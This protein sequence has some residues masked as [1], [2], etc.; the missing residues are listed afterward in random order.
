MSQYFF[1]LKENN[2]WQPAVQKIGAW[3]DNEVNEL[4]FQVPNELG[5]LDVHDAAI[6]L[7]AIR[8]D[9]MRLQYIID[10]FTHRVTRDMSLMGN[11][12]CSIKFM[13]G[14]GE[15]YATENFRLIVSPRVDT[16]E[17][18]NTDP[19]FFEEMWRKIQAIVEAGVPGPEGP[20]G[21]RGPRGRR[22]R[23]GTTGKAI[24]ILGDL[25]DESELPLEGTSGDAYL[26]NGYLWVWSTSQNKFVDMGN[27]QGPKGDTGETGLQGPRGYQGDKGNTGLQGN[28]GETGAVGPQGEQ[29]IEGPQGEQGVQGEAG[30][31]GPIGLQGEIGPVGPQGDQGIQ[32]ERGE[33]GVIGNT[34]PKGDTGSIGPQGEQGAG[35]NILG[36]FNTE[37]ELRDAHPTGSP[38]DAYMV[39]PEMWVWSVDDWINV[40][41][42]Q[43]PQ[44]DIGPQG[45]IGP[46]GDQG[47][48]G[49]KG[50]QGIQGEIGPTGEQGPIGNTGATGNTGPK[51]DQGVPG[52]QGPIGNTGST[53][54]TGAQG[55]QGIPGPQGDIGPEGPQGNIGPKGDTGNTGPTGNTG[56]TG[57]A[58]TSVT[59]IEAANDTQAQILS[60]ANPNNVYFVAVG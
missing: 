15:V 40:G 11:Y 20:P 49:E 46:K 21:E 55:E 10:D 25:N 23:Q 59:V 13:W 53:G 19:T 34:G 12:A 56:A 32:G 17:V 47:I 50:D 8:P 41:N 33:Q 60:Q 18:Y 26:I 2:T 1:T 45:N 31:T 35:V 14:N 6:T 54:A 7:H 51:G 42:I 39:G 4:I 37:Q 48:Q 38:G 28:T 16:D 22:G 5:G 52:E 9:G 27:I 29:G 44:G 30:P 57:P 3:R 58:G 36:S 43:G 24:D